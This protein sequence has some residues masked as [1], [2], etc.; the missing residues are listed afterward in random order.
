MM[1]LAGWSFNHPVLLA[2]A[3]GGVY[4][5]TKFLYGVIRPFWSPLRNLPGPKNRNLIWG[6]LQEIFKDEPAEAHI[7]WAYEYGPT[8][9]SLFFMM[10]RCSSNT[11]LIATTR[12]TKDFLTSVAVPFL[13]F[14]PFN[15]NFTS[16][17]CS[18]IVL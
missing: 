9:V 8:Y 11:R 14:Q 16:W 12:Y 17:V 3:A 18:G 1:D 10:T 13:C 7:R 2:I 6:H 4:F 5:T 15:Y